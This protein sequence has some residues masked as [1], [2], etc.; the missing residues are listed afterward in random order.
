MYKPAIDS[1]PYRI[2]IQTLGIQKLTSVLYI[3]FSQRE[4]NEKGK[5]IY[6]KI[7]QL[8][9]Y[10]AGNC[11]DDSV[12]KFEHVLKASMQSLLIRSIHRQ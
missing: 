8:I 2:K 5:S 6:C 1:I 11:T 7:S 3:Y 10:F 4:I 12:G 9:N